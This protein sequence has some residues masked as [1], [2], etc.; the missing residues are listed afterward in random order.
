MKAS[1]D[2]SELLL[3]LN[4][5]QR[6][7]TTY[8][9]GPS[10][11]LAG[12]GSGKTRVLVH[13]AVYLVTHLKILP[14]SVLMI[15]FTNK[16]AGEMKKRIEIMLREFGMPQTTLGFV[17]TFHSWCA[18]LLRHEGHLVGVDSR[19]LIFTEDD[20]KDI[21][22]HILKK[23]DIAKPAPSFFLNKISDAKNQLISPENFL[24]I[25]S[26]YKA[27]TA[28]EVYFEYQKELLIQRALDFDD[29]LFYACKLLREH[30]QV[31]A[32]YAKEFTHI[33]VDEFQDTNVA[34][35][36]LI[37]MLGMHT[38]NIT[39]VGDF[40]QAIYSW[41]GADIRNLERFS[42]DFPDAKVFSLEE[43]YRSSQTILD[44]AYSK[45]IENQSH[46]ILKLYTEKKAGEEVIE[47]EA[48]D[49]K[50]EAEYIANSIQDY[51]AAEM[52]RS[53]FEKSIA[54]TYSE[55]AVLYR[56]N[57]QSRIIE[58]TF[59]KFGIPYVLYGGTRFYERKEVK[60]LLAYIR[61]L[62]NPEDLVATD[63]VK[64]L[65]KRRWE[66]FRNA[67]SELVAATQEYT[68][69]L[70]IAAVLEKTKYLDFFDI[71]DPDDASRIENIREL[72][73]VAAA[74]KNLTDFF[75]RLSLIESEYGQ[76]EKGKRGKPTTGV[77][78]MSLHA[79][80]GLEFNTVFIVGLEEGIL[81][82]VRS[83]EDIYALEEE[84][85]LF[86]V[87]ITRARHK[88]FVTWA[89]HRAMWGRRTYGAKSRF[90]REA[91][92]D[93]FKKFDMSFPENSSISTDQ[94]DSQIPQYESSSSA[95]DWNW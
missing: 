5:A 22:K 80:K 41:R 2:S 47:Y 83:L 39:V 56:T 24:S 18:K 78:L 58:E 86:Y 84:R 65:G 23:M 49:E 45:I 92:E 59:L 50:Y 70:V 87:G 27:A 74:Q 76:A 19:F 1:K 37:R 67:Y 28:A 11:V 73:T 36:E 95:D 38:K 72:Q 25:Y 33:L 90:I 57:S 4:E 82:H 13:K 8:S 93:A 81:P 75:E 77:R 21:M 6:E 46:P 35:Y 52:G 64:K 79:A 17:G 32:R 63:R 26:F 15:T 53:S 51:A 91:D 69:D 66:T 94:S 43:N 85:R 16:A 54:D 7:A 61:L 60:D 9:D 3:G 20:Q 48:E 44:Y 42:K 55:Y 71:S 29:I 68:P 89:K 62:V 12:A 31:C 40:S 88:L 10:L 14:Q 34:Q 30:P